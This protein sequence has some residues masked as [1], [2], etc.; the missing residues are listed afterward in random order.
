MHKIRS[1]VKNKVDLGSNFLIDSQIL[2]FWTRSCQDSWKVS[3]HRDPRDFCG[4]GISS[5]FWVPF[6]TLRINLACWSCAE[7]Y[8]PLVTSVLDQGPYFLYFKPIFPSTAPCACYKRLLFLWYIC[9]D[10][11]I[12]GLCWRIW[13]TWRGPSS[14]YPWQSHFCCGVHALSKAATPWY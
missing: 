14:S 2:Q 5:V 1:S 3:G 9:H 12:R 11:S 7:D 8:W 13:K 10:L 6:N 4:K